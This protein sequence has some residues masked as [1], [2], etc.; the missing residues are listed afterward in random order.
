VDIASV[1]EQ[2][3]RS[4]GRH[5]PVPKGDGTTKLEDV[6]FYR[7]VD[8]FDKSGDGEDAGQLLLP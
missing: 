6:Q 1:G 8:E 7:N 5:R 4:R 2:Q 3:A